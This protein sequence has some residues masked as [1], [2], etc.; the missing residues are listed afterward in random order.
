MRS[1]L[2][3]NGVPYDVAMS[4]PEWMVLAHVVTFGTLD[5]GKFDWQRMRWEDSK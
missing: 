5:G 2:L 4:M 3:K 1:I